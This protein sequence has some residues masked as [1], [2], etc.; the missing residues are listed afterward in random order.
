MTALKDL[1]A[2]LS[3]ARAA[4]AQT[5]SG[6][7]HLDAKTEEERLQAILT[8]I[9]Q[10]ILPRT[11]VFNIGE[12]RNL[13]IEAGDGKLRGVVEVS[14]KDLENADIAIKTEASKSRQRIAAL[15]VLS[16]FVKEDGALSVLPQPPEVF[17]TLGLEGLTPSEILSAEEDAT[18]EQDPSGT[19]KAQASK[20]TSSDEPLPDT[21]AGAYYAAV[22]GFSTARALTGDDGGVTTKSGDDQAIPLEYLVRT[23]ASQIQMNAVFMDTA[24]PGPKAIYMGSQADDMPSAICFDDGKTQVVATVES[25]DVDQALKTAALVLA[26]TP[27]D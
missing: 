7:R 12:D 23:F 4:T 18:D 2:L 17:T 16:A 13:K 27:E 8:E 11:L 9:G 19:K 10:T 3:H 26:D 6:K 24:M 21:P 5:T 15:E 22:S 20:N 14:P 25:S 1:Q